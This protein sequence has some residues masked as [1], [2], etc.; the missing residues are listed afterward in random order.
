MKKKLRKVI[1]DL[2]PTT[3]EVTSKDFW[4]RINRI[5]DINERYKVLLTG[6]IN[7][8]LK[9]VQRLLAVTDKEVTALN[10][11]FLYLELD[12]VRYHLFKDVVAGTGHLG[13]EE[14]R[15]AAVVNI[16]HDSYARLA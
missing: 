15:Q 3:L 16:V 11:K 7:F 5:E 6:T 9:G 4:S 1:F 14:I 12:G 2:T 13:L 10:N 8:K